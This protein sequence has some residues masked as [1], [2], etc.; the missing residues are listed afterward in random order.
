MIIDVRHLNIK[1]KIWT[2]SIDRLLL[3]DTVRHEW[4]V[5]D[6]ETRAERKHMT[7]IDCYYLVHNHV[8]RQESVS[9]LIKTGIPRGAL[10]RRY[11]AGFH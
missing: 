5:C 1:E 8:S 7:S 9:L 2:G 11:L 10:S 6:D 3:Y 4:T